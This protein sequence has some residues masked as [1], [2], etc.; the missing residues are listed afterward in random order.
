MR[1]F[2]HKWLSTI[3]R[4]HIREK[5]IVYGALQ[6]NTVALNYFTIYLFIF[7]SPLA[8][9]FVLLKTSFF[10]YH[11]QSV[12][13]PHNYNIIEGGPKNIYISKYFEQELWSK[14]SC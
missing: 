10:F 11:N 8:S 1:E 9:K 14:I 12:Y 2:F 4:R 3:A 5:V 6:N 7:F 13:Y